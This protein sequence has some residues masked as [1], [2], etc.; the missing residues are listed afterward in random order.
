[1]AGE[2][3][4][5]LEIALELLKTA[6]KLSPALIEWLQQLLHGTDPMTLRVIDILPDERSKSEGVYEELTGQRG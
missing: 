2:K 1:M 5:N 3:N 6:L 4:D